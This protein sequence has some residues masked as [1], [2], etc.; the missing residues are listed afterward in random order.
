MHTH[1]YKVAKIFYARLE[2][3]SYI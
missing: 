3:L 2:L 1:F